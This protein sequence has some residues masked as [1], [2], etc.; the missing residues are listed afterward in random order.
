MPAS[1]PSVGEISYVDLGMTGRSAVATVICQ[2]KWGWPD[3]LMIAN[4]EVD[5]TTIFQGVNLFQVARRGSLTDTG[6]TTGF[7]EPT[8]LGFDPA[9]STLYI[10]CGSGNKGFI[11]RPGPDGRSGT[12]DD[13]VSALTNVGSPVNGMFGDGDKVGE[14]F[15]GS[16]A[17]A[18]NI[19]HVTE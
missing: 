14:A 13:Q 15:E 11:D 3:R 17:P 12:P 4:S 16:F 5:G 8:G 1:E 10:S 2:T 9:T 6:D 18:L 7:T 19:E